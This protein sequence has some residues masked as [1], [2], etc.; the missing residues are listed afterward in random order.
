MLHDLQSLSVPHA[1]NRVAINIKTKMLVRVFL[2][3]INIL[4]VNLI[5]FVAFYAMKIMLHAYACV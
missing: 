4:Y 5:N 1:V 3:I 2:F